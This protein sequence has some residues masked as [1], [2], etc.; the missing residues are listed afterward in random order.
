[1]TFYPFPRVSP[2]GASMLRRDLGRIFDEM[3]P[4]SPL[5]VALSGNNQATDGAS[6]QAAGGTDGS[7]SSG[8][9]PQ[10]APRTEARETPTSWVFELDLPGVAPESVSVLAAEGILTVEGSRVAREPAGGEKSLFSE[11]KTGGFRRRF[12][13]PGNADLQQVTA[14]YALG[15]LTVSV[16][17]PEPAQ[18]RRVPV[19]VST[20]EPA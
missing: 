14:S 20:T 15:V 18:T 19:S 10:W 1:M 9:L 17:K 6:S 3:L 12:R 2:M 13:L 5:T 16:A 11:R 7:A 8:D 4:F